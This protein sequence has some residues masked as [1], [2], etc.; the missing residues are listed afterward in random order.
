MTRVLLSYMVAMLCFASSL[1]A[2]DTIPPTFTS[3][4]IN[5]ILQLS[6]GA[7][8]TV[9]NF[10]ITAVDNAPGC[11]PTVSQTDG[12]GYTSGST[13]P[14]GTVNLSFLATDC[15]GNTATCAFSI[16]GKPIRSRIEWDDL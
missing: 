14:I 7:C 9:Y 3:C 4:P 8:E 2:Q 15:S 13:Y 11:N 12:T 1:L 5:V 16:Y 10:S 6:P